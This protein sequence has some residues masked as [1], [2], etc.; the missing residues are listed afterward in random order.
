MVLSYG[1]RATNDRG[2]M[3]NSAFICQHHSWLCRSEGGGR[4]GVL[5][6]HPT[7][8]RRWDVEPVQSVASSGRHPCIRVPRSWAMASRKCWGGR[9]SAFGMVGKENADPET[10]AGIVYPRAARIAWTLGCIFVAHLGS[11]VRASAR[12]ST[13]LSGR[14]AAI[15]M[16]YR[17]LLARS[18]KLSRFVVRDLPVD[19]LGLVNDPQ[20]PKAQLQLPQGMLCRVSSE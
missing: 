4:P 5:L 17:S 12:K 11:F 3:L 16:A 14:W 2:S 20:I 7:S 10:V 19:L 9:R 18:P 1:G 13:D 15:Q 8:P 6:L